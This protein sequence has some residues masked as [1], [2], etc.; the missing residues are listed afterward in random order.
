MDRRYDVPTKTPI[1]ILTN[2]SN[3]DKNQALFRINIQIK[4]ANILLQLQ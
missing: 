2:R 4:E 1:I 3:Q